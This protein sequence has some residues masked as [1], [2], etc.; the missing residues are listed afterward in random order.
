M[1]TFVQPPE[2]P[3]CECGVTTGEPHRGSHVDEPI[4]YRHAF[5]PANPWVAKGRCGCHEALPPLDPLPS[6]RGS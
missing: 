3:V 6:E 5:C 2:P 4:S 1:P